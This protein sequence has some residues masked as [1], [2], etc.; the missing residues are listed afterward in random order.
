MKV[1][2]NEMNS[3]GFTVYT[4]HKI[5]LIETVTKERAFADT[6]GTSFLNRYFVL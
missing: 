6:W 1:V 4:V 3:S 2:P 5:L